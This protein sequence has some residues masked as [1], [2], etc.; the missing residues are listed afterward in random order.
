[1]VSYQ[2]LTKISK[3]REPPKEDEAGGIWLFINSPMARNVF[4]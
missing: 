1:M 2:E 3:T 4:I